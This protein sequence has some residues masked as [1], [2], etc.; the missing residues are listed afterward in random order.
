[1]VMGSLYEAYQKML[2]SESWKKLEEILSNESFVQEIDT[3]NI[4]DLLSQ[5]R[6]LI[7]DA[8]GIDPSDKKYFIAGSAR[9]FKNP[10]LLK[11]LNKMD[12]NFPLRIGDLDVIV[13]NES[14]WKV[15]YKNYTTDSE[16][17]R[18]LSKK[19]GEKN[20]PKVVDGFKEQWK[21]YGG[22]VYRPGK[23]GLNLTEKDMEVFTEWKPQMAKAE[24]TRNFDIRSTE[25]ILND[26]VNIGGFNYMSVFDVFDYKNN[27]SRPK[28]AR[29]VEFMKEY[30][31]SAETPQDM[32]RLFKNIADTIAQKE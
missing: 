5:S 7:F 22:K 6:L 19:I 31:S 32:E 10:G 17:I 30:L 8:F 9:L 16:F 26:S 1:M 27:L 29:I 28:E 23:G 15:L 20:I 13:P 11:V 2:I 21:K 18:E 4:N 3:V 24:G 25:E 12:K 14:D